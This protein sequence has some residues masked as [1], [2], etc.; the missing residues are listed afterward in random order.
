[1]R[2]TRPIRH[3]LALVTLAALPVVPVAG[4][5]AQSPTPPPADTGKTKA[6]LLSSDLFKVGADGKMM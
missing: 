1:M 5:W 4:L 2:P 6:V 3:L